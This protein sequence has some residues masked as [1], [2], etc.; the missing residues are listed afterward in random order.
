MSKH[1]WIK[2]IAVPVPIYRLFDYKT[3][4]DIDQ[5]AR[6]LIPFGKRQLVGIVVSD[7]EPNE[8]LFQLDKLKPISEVLDT[9]LLSV[10][11]IELANWIARYY[12]VPIGMVYE[13][14]LPV[15]LRKGGYLNTCK[16][17]RQ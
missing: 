6:V 17:I 14:I 3:N 7:V 5:G 8:S 2:R 4:Q 13:L 1:F 16:I 10:K 15:R 11:M 12:L 9:S